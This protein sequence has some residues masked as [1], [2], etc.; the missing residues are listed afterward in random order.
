MAEKDLIQTVP[1]GSQFWDKPFNQLINAVNGLMGGVEPTHLTSVFTYVN[2]VTGSG[3]EAWYWTL[4][5]YKLVFLWTGS[6][7]TPKNFVH[8]CA[9]VTVPDAIAPIHET[10]ILVSRG[11]ILINGY[12]KTNTFHVFTANAVDG[13]TSGIGSVFYIARN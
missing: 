1:H 9:G 8:D 7:Q 6:F 13:E 10:N 2:G 11:S 3:G 4:G 12:G 5:N